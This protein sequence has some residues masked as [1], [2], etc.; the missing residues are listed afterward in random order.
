MGGGGGANERQVEV[1]SIIK[2]LT[3]ILLRRNKT[4]GKIRNL[5]FREKQ[6]VFKFCMVSVTVWFHDQVGVATSSPWAFSITQLLFKCT[7]FNKEMKNNGPQ[8]LY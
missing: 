1:Y 6:G 4:V 2:L 7:A 5:S 3:S 8:C